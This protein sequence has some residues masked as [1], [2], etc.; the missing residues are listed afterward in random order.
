MIQKRTLL[1][2]TSMYT[3]SLVFQKILAFVYFILLARTFGAS[4]VGAYTFALSFS[5]LFSVFADLG[6]SPYITRETAKS[7]ISLQKLFSQA[8]PTKIALV[9]LSMGI[10][11]LAVWFGEYADEMRNFI[12]ITTI[13]MGADMIALLLYGMLRGRQDLRFES[14]AMAC[15]QLGVVAIG[16]TL[17]YTGTELLTLLALLAYASLLNMIYAGWVV[18]RRLKLT[19]DWRSYRIREAKNMLGIAL[20]FALAGIF[21]KIY[22]YLDTVLLG[23]MQNE[24]AVGFYSVPYKLTFA[25]QFLPMAFAAAAYPA[26]S[27]AFAHDKEHLKRIFEQTFFYLWFLSIPI[28]IGVYVLADEFVLLLYGDAFIKSIPALKILILSLPFIFLSFPLG[29]LLNATNQQK[30]N[31]RNFG[32]VMVINILL[33]LLLIPRWSFIG[34]SIAGLITYICLATLGLWTTRKNI[35]YKDPF[36]GKLFVKSGIAVAVMTGSIIL[37]KELLWLPVLVGIAA[38]VYGA[39][40]ALLKGFRKEDIVQLQRLLQKRGS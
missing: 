14:V 37:L 12:T 17:L 6:I 15:Y 9:M 3:L 31:T 23:I 25:L 18:A 30:K 40:F 5:L 10:V 21:V 35:A 39:T 22:S 38:L 1:A 4:D 33:N 24:T 29:S 8:L 13:V 27:Y 32:M 28:A 20:P 34:A 36:Y 2:N 19:I 7:D 11:A 16:G 26:M